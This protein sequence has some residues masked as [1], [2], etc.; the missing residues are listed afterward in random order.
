MKGPCRNHENARRWES[1]VSEPLADMTVDGWTIVSGVALK[2]GDGVVL[3]CKIC[4]KERKPV[5]LDTIRERLNL[6]KRFQC[7]EC[8]HLIDETIKQRRFKKGPRDKGY[9]VPRY[10]FKDFDK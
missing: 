5:L 8:T 3:R 10:T 7:S 4:L 6:G 9:I 1:D 2:G